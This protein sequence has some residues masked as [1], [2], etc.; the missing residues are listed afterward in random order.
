MLEPVS[1]F[2]TLATLSEHASYLLAH[3]SDLSSSDSYAYRF[4]S[5]MAIAVV[6][7]TQAIAYSINMLQDPEL[8][9][10]SFVSMLDSQDE[11]FCESR[12]SMWNQDLGPAVPFGPAPF[13]TWAKLQRV[14][15]KRW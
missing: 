7:R 2:N 13:G 15:V 9:Q 6:L 11:F 5:P 12:T 4:Q 3:A 14:L 10:S 8:F 1:V